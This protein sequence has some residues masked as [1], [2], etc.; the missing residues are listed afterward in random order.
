MP[1][2]LTCLHYFW[3]CSTVPE[4]KKIFRENTVFEQKNDSSKMTP[5]HGAVGRTFLR[6]CLD[7][8]SEKIQAASAKNWRHHGWWRLESSKE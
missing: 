6:K 5:A 4:R 3:G 1:T 8:S 7:Q 2:T